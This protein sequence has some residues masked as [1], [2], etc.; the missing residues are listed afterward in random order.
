[1]DE[2]ASGRAH[3]PLP[4]PETAASNIR[5]F[6][7]EHRSGSPRATS[8]V[9]QVV[10]GGV[11]RER[12]ESASGNLTDPDVRL[13]IDRLRRHRGVEDL[14][15]PDPS[16]DDAGLRRGRRLRLP[17]ASRGES[18]FR[19]A[20]RLRSRRGGQR[21]VR[22]RHPRTPVARNRPR[23]G[24]RAPAP[25]LGPL[26]RGWHV[27]RASRPDGGRDPRS[28]LRL[29]RRGT[30][31]QPARWS[32]T[33]CGGFAVASPQ[34]IP[35]SARRFPS[36]SWRRVTPRSAA[37]CRTG[38]GFCGWPRPRPGPDRP[39]GEHLFHEYHPPVP[40]SRGHGQY[41]LR[42]RRLRYVGAGEQGPERG[43]G[44]ASAIR[45]VVSFCLR[46][47]GHR[48]VPGPCVGFWT[49]PERS[50]RDS[51]CASTRLSGSAMC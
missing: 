11:A 34:P 14:L 49:A 47:R 42:S 50:S 48:G 8:V 17:P 39:A 21:S 4:A 28:G 20:I 23:A 26:R 16:G 27:V 10:A 33:A 6:L 18:I 51:G 41:R 44:R 45:P 13:A 29:Y 24:V 36:F 43:P 22:S 19:P 1:M 3:D 9:L 2:N 7:D 25:R 31:A 32:G 40:V 38:S 30:T 46:G 35:C 5:R 12:I 15:I 37:A